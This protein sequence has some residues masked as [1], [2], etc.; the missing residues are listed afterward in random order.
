MALALADQRDR[1]ESGTGSST[2]GRG[3]VDDQDES[4]LGGM[5]GVNDL[6]T[7]GEGPASEKGV[8]QGLYAEHQTELYK[9][10]PVVNVSDLRRSLIADRCSCF[11]LCFRPTN[12]I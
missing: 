1:T 4:V 5:L 7:A 8:M 11:L 2:P 10:P 6:P 12:D 9:P 3:R